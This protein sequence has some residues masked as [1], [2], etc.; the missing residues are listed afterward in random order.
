MK[1]AEALWKHG[2]HIS[3][4]QDGEYRLILYQIDS[5]YVEVWYHTEGNDI[6]K[7][8]TF[9]STTQLEPYFKNIDIRL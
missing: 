1:Q 2:V 8:R 9:S 4:R 5:F 3:E 7:F 6:R